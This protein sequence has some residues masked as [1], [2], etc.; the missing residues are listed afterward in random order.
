VG[1]GHC[2]SSQE[3]SATPPSRPPGPTL[4]RLGWADHPW[5]YV[6]TWSRVKHAVT[7]THELLQWVKAAHPYW[8]RTAG[9][10]HV[11]HFA[12]DEG[13]CWAPEEVYRNSIILTHWGRMDADHVSGTTYYPVRGRGTGVRD[14]RG[15]RVRGAASVQRLGRD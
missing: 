12:H 4:L 6:D 3:P 8:N 10:D 13:A 5:W 11:W 14:G 7:L 1:Q 15:G 2:A 9:A